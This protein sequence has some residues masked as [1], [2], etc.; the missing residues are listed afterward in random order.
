MPSNPHHDPQRQLPILWF[1][2]LASVALILA[3]AWFL[4][5]LMPITPIAALSQALL[6]A[7]LVA[8]PVAF[9]FVRWLVPAPLPRPTRDA[10]LAQAPAVPPPDA[11]RVRFIVALTLWEIPAILALIAVLTGADPAQALGIGSASLLLLLWRRPS[12]RA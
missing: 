2:Q 10:P 7:A 1:G 9:L 12:A 4:P 3:L 6:L 5:G 8:V 11:Q